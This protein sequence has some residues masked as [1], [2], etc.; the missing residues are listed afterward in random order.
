MP[1][2]SHADLDPL[3]PTLNRT[4][5]WHHSRSHAIHSGIWG[6]TY[7]SLSLYEVFSVR[8]Y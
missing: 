5:T 6:D 1:R 8:V 7:L 2:L 3:S 4:L